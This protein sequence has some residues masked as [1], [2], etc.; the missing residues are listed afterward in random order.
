MQ[1]AAEPGMNEAEGAQKQREKMSAIEKECTEKSGL[2]CDVVTLYGGG[3]YNLYKYKKYTDVRVVF[4]PEAQ[5]AFFG[6]DHDNFEYPRYDLDI[7]YFRVYEHD[8][9]VHLTDYLKWSSTGTKA[10]D[11][12]FVSGN[13]GGTER[14]LTMAE[15]SFLKDVQTPFVIDMLARRDKVLHEYAAQSPENAR[16]A[17]DD[18]FYVENSLKAYK[19]RLDGLKDKGLM[20]KKATAEQKLRAA[21]DADPKLKAAYASAW[22]EIA[23]A[24]EVR[25]RLFLQYTFV[26]RGLGFNSEMARYARTLV[27]VTAEKQ[28]PNP[29]RL[30]EYSDARLP[31]LEQQL[32]STAPVYRS[33]EVV[34]LAE[35]LE[36][37]RDKLGA[38]DPTVKRALGGKTP[39]EAAKAYIDGSKLD[40]PAIRKQL[41]QGGASAVAQSTDPLIV[42]MREIDPEPAS[43]ASS[44]TTKWTRWFA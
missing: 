44:M 24:M 21:V 39:A 5:I 4:A 15:L 41:Y 40:D 32:F 10:G 17:G 33:L 13:P 34:T 23:K 31:S 7:T 2:R 1:S 27:R 18:I 8:K 19:G 12:V 35:S 22:D 37:M 30:R 43:C 11:L 42:L 29:L 36:Q 9:P 28:K 3:M 6:G 25:K 38:D 20:A 14:Q 26:E 16:V